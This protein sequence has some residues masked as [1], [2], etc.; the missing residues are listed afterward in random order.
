MPYL[1][2]TAVALVFFLISFYFF[3]RKA[4]AAFGQ[5]RL[6]WNPPAPYDPRLLRF[7]LNAAIFRMIFVL[8]GLVLLLL[9]VYL[10]RYQYLTDRATL[11]G[12]IVFQKGT[13]EYRSDAGTGMSARVQGHQAAMAGIILR[14]PTWLRFVGLGNYHKA[15]TF[16]GFNQNEYHYNTPPADWLQTYADGLFVFCYK[17]KS[18]LKTP[19]AIYVESPYFN[20][21]KHQVF[22]THSGYIV[23]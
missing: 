14:F 17:N 7:D 13:A 21:G 2:F 9:A 22:V 1:H 18:W 4:S 23:D 6:K 16:R 15:V 11:A 10:S 5:L 3:L 12:V 20:P 19:E 8:I